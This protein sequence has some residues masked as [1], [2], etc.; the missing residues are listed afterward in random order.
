MYSEV[1]RGK[2]HDVHYLPLTGSGKKN[3][4]CNIYKE[5]ANDETNGIKC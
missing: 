2:G 3:Q 5:Y 1:F 4:I